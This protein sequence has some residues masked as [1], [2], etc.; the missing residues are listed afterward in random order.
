MYKTRLKQDKKAEVVFETYKGEIRTGDIVAVDLGEN[1]VSEKSG[2]RPA[3][4]ISNAYMN[5][6]SPNVIVAPITKASNKL[7]SDGNIKKYATQVI[8]YQDKY[9]SLNE[10][11]VIQVEDVRSINKGR[12]TS[13]ITVLQKEEKSKLDKAIMKTFNFN[14]DE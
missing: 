11:S 5:K 8:L 3:V 13:R 6:K 7:D 9:K 14:V 1:L 12:I 4:V 10:D 2:M